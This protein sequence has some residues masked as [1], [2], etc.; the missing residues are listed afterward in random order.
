L[1]DSRVRC[2][3]DDRRYVVELAL[4]RVVAFGLQPDFNGKTHEIS[5]G[6]LTAACEVGANSQ[7]VALADVEIA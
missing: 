1:P 4:V 2:R 5:A 7:H 3:I 6:C